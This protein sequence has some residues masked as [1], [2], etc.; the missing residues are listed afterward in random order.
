MR[1]PENIAEQLSL[2]KDRNM[3]TR[4]SNSAEETE[5]RARDRGK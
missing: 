2:E 3:L 4:L 1:V 5:L